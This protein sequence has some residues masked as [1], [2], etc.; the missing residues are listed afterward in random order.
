MIIYV[1]KGKVI[2]LKNMIM[3]FKM[4]K[5]IYLVSYIK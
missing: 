3:K 4:G 5:L 1:V 2:D